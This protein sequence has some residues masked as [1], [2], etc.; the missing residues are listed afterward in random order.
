MIFIELIVV[1]TTYYFFNISE[2][3]LHKISHNRN[4]GGI[5]YRWHHKHHVIEYPPHKLTKDVQPY[6]PKYE[7]IYVY[8][9][10]TWWIALYNIVSQYY[11]TIIF[12]ETLLY[13]L[14]I[15]RLH[16]Y[17]HLNNSPLE[18]FK[19]FQKK[20]ELHLLHHKK[21]YHNFNLIDFTSD[22][23]LETYHE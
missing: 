3:I 23:L 11:F 2:Y 19:W 21:T 1:L 8:F 18:K 9:L 7:N 10:I 22:K 20:K 4:Y 16:T 5:I 14:C 6:S 12:T 13:A 17:Y 15:D